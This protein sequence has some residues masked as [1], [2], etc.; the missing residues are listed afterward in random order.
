MLAR[1]LL[2]IL[3]LLLLLLRDPEIGARPFQPSQGKSPPLD[4][5]GTGEVAP[6]ARVHLPETRRAGRQALG[7]HRTALT[8]LSYGLPGA[9]ARTGRARWGAGGGK[10]LPCGD[11]P[12]Q[13]D[14]GGF[15]TG[16]GGGAGG[17]LSEE[18]SKTGARLAAR[19]SWPRGGQ[20]AHSRKVPGKTNKD[21]NSIRCSRVEAYCR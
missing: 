10:K 19:W 12:I 2:P 16:G 1:A 5:R 11:V 6:P 15:R 7:T 21:P 20:K 17:G 13:P 14:G 3:L 9:Y 18:D 4:Q 8:S